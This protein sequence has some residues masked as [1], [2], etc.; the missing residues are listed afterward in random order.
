[1]LLASHYWRIGSADEMAEQLAGLR[2]RL[3]VSHAVAQED[4]VEACAP[5]VALLAGK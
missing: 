1:M 2:E 5:I 3:G 4:A